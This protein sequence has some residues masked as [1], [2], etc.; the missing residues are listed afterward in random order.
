MNR[1][2]ASTPRERE[3]YTIL[4]T[5]MLRAPET[6]QYSV[7]PRLISATFSRRLMKVEITRN[8]CETRDQAGIMVGQT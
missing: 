1:T 7:G 8:R 4:D 3:R 5:L 2:K 6:V